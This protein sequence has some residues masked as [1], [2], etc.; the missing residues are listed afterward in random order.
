MKHHQLFV[1]LIAVFVAVALTGCKGNSDM[2]TEVIAA[3]TMVC[4]SCENNVKKAV[5][6][7]EG[8]KSVDVDLKGKMV[9]VQFLPAKTNL[10]TIERAITDAGYDANDKQRDPGAYE[11]LDACCKAK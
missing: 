9:T 6:A 1:A 11:A 7:V 3:K 4:G 2:K 8:V 5:Y 10:V